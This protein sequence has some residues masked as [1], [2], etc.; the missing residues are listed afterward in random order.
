MP[1]DKKLSIRIPSETHDQL[2]LIKAVI[3][4]NMRSQIIESIQTMYDRCIAESP[5]SIR[6]R[7]QIKENK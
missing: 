5:A 6:N 7:L 4:T 1:E 2:R 3:G